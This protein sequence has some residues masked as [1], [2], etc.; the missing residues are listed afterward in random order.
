MCIVMI[1]MVLPDILIM[2][3]YWN[4][5]YNDKCNFIKLLHEKMYLYTN[6][7]EIFNFWGDGN[8]GYF[9]IGII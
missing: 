8:V 1:W 9:H 7:I 2:R 6:A 3:Y 4:V 5:N